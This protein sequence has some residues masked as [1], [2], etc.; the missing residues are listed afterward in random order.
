MSAATEA[1]RRFFVGPAR[2]EP[3]MPVEFMGAD[4]ERGLSVQIESL[5]SGLTLLHATDPESDCMS[6]RAVLL[7]PDGDVGLGTDLFG[8][9][10]ANGGLECE[11]RQPRIVGDPATQTAVVRDGQE[12]LLLV[13]TAPGWTFARTAPSV[14]CAPR[15]VATACGVGI[16]CE[17]GGAMAGLVPPLDDR[18]ARCLEAAFEVER[19]FD[20]AIVAADARAATALAPL[21]DSN[22]DTTVPLPDEDQS[23]HNANRAALDRARR[24]VRT[25]FV[26]WA[27]EHGDG[28]RPRGNQRAARRRAAAANPPTIQAFCP[29]AHG[30]F[31]LTAGFDNQPEGPG[32]EVFVTSKTVWR[33]DGTSATLLDSI[34]ENELH[35]ATVADI[36]GDGAAELIVYTQTWESPSR[37]IRAYSASRPQFVTLWADEAQDGRTRDERVMVLRDEQRTVL[38]VD[39]IAHRW[40]GRALAP[41]PLQSSA[42][43]GALSRR[44]S[45]HDARATARDAI[46]RATL[47]ARML[48]DALTVAGVEPART[49]QLLRALSAR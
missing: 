11:P 26:E 47:D 30:A 25:Q 38:L 35:G 29:D 32:S 12:A 2:S 9:E 7:T 45:A 10:F 19:E 43:R 37:R 17:P 42:L 6:H 20:R 46:A 13:R 14:T 39:W 3:P 36:D 24:L 4:G 15:E 28:P 49:Q 22:N 1:W 31:L 33:F 44:S 41:T 8:R 18:S 40:T 16:F 5:P 34:D 48:D 23:C 21:I 27:I